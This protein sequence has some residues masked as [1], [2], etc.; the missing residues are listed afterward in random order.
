MTGAKAFLILAMVELHLTVMSRRIRANKFV[1]DVQLSS[2]FSNSVG[3]SRL[4]LEK[5][6]VNSKPLSVCIHSTVIPRRA[7]Y[8]VSLRRKFA[9]GYVDCSG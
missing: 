5:R 4:L 1:P 7:Y 2:V 8:V 3:K 9:E 6:L